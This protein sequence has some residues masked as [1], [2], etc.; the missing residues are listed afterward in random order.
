MVPECWNEPSS[1][2]SFFI[3]TLDLPDTQQDVD[4]LVNPKRLRD[5]RACQR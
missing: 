1:S 5:S 3:Y 2:Q 4:V